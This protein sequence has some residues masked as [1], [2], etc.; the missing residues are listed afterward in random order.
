MGAAGLR[1]IT[2]TVWVPGPH[3]ENLCIRHTPEN[4]PEGAD[5]VPGK[6]SGKLRPW[7]TSPLVCCLFGC[8]TGNSLDW[9]PSKAVDSI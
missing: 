8:L 7:S 2:G 6:A 3:F 9:W 5:H 4:Q 1:D